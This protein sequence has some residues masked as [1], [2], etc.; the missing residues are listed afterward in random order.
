MCQ[1]YGPATCASVG[2][3]KGVLIIATRSTRADRPYTLGTSRRLGRGMM[4]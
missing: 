4:L 3:Q 2:R 1:I